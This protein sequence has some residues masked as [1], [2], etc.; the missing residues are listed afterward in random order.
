MLDQARQ[1][2]TLDH[3]PGGTAGDAVERRRDV[4]GARIDRRR[5]P[6]LHRELAAVRDRIAHHHLACAEV[7]G[8]ERDRDPDRT[9]PD[10]EDGFSLFHRRAVER[11]VRD[12]ERF[13]EGA[14]TVVDRLGQWERTG[15]T[16][17]NAHSP[18]ADT[19][20]TQHGNLLPTIGDRSG[21]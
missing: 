5:R 10:D 4:F 20:F 7:A 12:R 18:R 6:H 11:V 17:L 16:D 3:D 2:D 19:P 1:T 21:R 13:D 14:V 8:P 15:V 9:T